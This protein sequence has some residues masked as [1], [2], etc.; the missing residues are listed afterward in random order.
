ML[1]RLPVDRV[2]IDRSFVRNVNDSRGNE[3][4][5]RSIALIARNFEMT[6]IAE[7]VETASQASLLREIGCDQVQG[8]LYSH[9]LGCADFGRW[10]ALHARESAAGG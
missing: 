2:K 9:A 4:I 1:Q 5:V 10:L 6:V 7:G 3:A 8:F